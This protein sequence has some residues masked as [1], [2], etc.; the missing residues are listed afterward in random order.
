MQHINQDI[1]LINKPKI[2]IINKN[3]PKDKLR[4]KTDNFEAIILKI[5]LDNALKNENNIFA[6]KNDPANN[7]YKSMYREE[8][9]NASAG[10]FGFSELLYNYLSNKNNL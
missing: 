10:S 2:P 4:E 8:L 6:D 5:L 9:A 1:T 3:T 7:I